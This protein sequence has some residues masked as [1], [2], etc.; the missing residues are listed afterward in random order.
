MVIEHMFDVNG[1]K[2]G[3]IRVWR[4]AFV[5]IAAVILG[6]GPAR[7]Q[8]PV[9]ATFAFVPYA[10]SFSLESKQPDIVDPLV[11]VISPHAPPGTGL[12][13][14]AHLPGI[15]N[16]RMADD[17][18]Q[19]ALDAD[20]KPLGFDLQHWFAAT[21]I[22]ELVPDGGRARITTRFTNLVPNGRYSLFVTRSDARTAPSG[23]SPLDGAGRANSF[24]AGPDGTGGVTVVSP[25][26][27]AH[28]N[29]I[30]LVFH[31]DHTDHGLQRG[32]PGI[33]AHVQLAAPIP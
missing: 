15:R 24:A 10:A 22:A 29:A 16:A 13:G 14:I 30:L 23:V 20:G 25:F 8:T 33:Y 2:L 26:A 7:A 17:P 18:M 6:A 3:S 19:P 9:P 11:F 21:G 31:S 32:E 28:P 5:A 27:L 4:A 1:G 12:L